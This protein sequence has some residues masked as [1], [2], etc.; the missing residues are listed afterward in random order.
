[1]VRDAIVGAGRIGLIQPHRLDDDNQAP[2][3]GRLSRR[4][5]RCRGTR[6]RERF[7]IVLH[8]VEPL[9][10]AAR[11]ATW[12]HSTAAR[13]WT[14]KRSIPYAA[15]LVPT[16]RLTRSPAPRR[17]F[18]WAA[19][20]RCPRN[21]GQRNRTGRAVRRGRQN[22]LCSSSRRSDSRADLL[23]QPTQFHRLANDGGV[24]IEPTIQ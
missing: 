15:P 17:S 16:R 20:A 6:R 2:P 24:E 23:V 7:N 22:R 14:S 5:G 12:T 13:R 4:V 1:M 21:A 11:G 3:R 8:G 10:S 18:T 19:V 9:P